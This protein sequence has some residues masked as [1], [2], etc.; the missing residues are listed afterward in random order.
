MDDDHDGS[1]GEDEDRDPKEGKRVQK[2]KKYATPVA[3][4]IDVAREKLKIVVREFKFEPGQSEEKRKKREALT[5][6]LEAHTTTLKE[7][8]KTQFSEA[9]ELYAH[10]KIVRMII[11]SRMR[12][13]SDRT[14]YYWLEPTP[15]KEKTVQSILI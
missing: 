8:L 10:T 11:E 6:K 7:I 3:E 15:G 13:G 5:Y 14:V 4:F 1:E 9:Y 12:F 2:K